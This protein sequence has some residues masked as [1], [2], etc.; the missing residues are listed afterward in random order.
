MERKLAD[1]RSDRLSLGDLCKAGA[2]TAVPLAAMI[3][4]FLQELTTARR[5]KVAE[6]K[7]A[8]ER[9]AG[10]PPDLAGGGKRV[11]GIEPS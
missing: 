3:Q 6:A 4:I 7:A 11:E 5:E 10:G 8:L 1:V 2:L 9:V